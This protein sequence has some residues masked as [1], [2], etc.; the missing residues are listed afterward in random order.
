MS[1]AKTCPACGLIIPPGATECDCGANLSGTGKPSGARPLTQG[2]RSPVSRGIQDPLTALAVVVIKVSAWLA[3][4]GGFVGA[5]A[6]FN[7]RSIVGMIGEGEKLESIAEIYYLTALSL[8]AIASGIISWAFLLVIA[9][10]AEHLL[11]L[12]PHRAGRS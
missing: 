12:D 7:S 10:V 3:L 1:R 11:S 5:S 9:A 4:A 6:F 2:D 8:S